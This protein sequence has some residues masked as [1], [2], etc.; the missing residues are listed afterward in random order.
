MS[1][2]RPDGRA[3]S[4]LPRPASLEPLWGRLDASRGLRLATAPGASPAL[5]R[6]LA[7]QQRRIDALT[8]PSHEDA[9][10]LRIAV[11]HDDG[12]RP[13]LDDDERFSLRIT[14]AGAELWAA[15]R[16]GVAHGLERVLQLVD[17]AGPG[18]GL[19]A[20]WIDDAPRF[21][22]RGLMLDLARRPY[23]LATLLRTLDGMAA[24]GLNVLHLHLNDDQGFAIEV[25]GT[26]E[27]HTHGGVRGH[28]GV[29]EVRRLVDEAADRSI[30]V[31]PEL[32]VPG[33]AGAIL[34]ARPELAAGTPP[35]GLPRRFGPGRHALDPSR[36]ATWTLL[37]A[38]V[39]DLADLFP[40]PVL[41]LGGDEVHPEVY[42]F[43][44][45][46]R[47][48]WMAE[49]DLE[50]ARAVQDWFLARMV[51]LLARHDR[52]PVG[53][54]ETLGPRTP[55]TLTIQAWRGAGALEAA[56]AAGHDA[57]FSS[58]WYLDLFYPAA[59]HYA[60]DPGAGA[61]DL[62][63]AER[64]LLG[65]PEL[66][67]VRRGL[68]G[69][70]ASAS[71]PGGRAGAPRGRLLGGEGCL[72]SELAAPH[73]LD[74][75]L[76]GRLAAVAERLWSSPASDAE[77]EL[78]DFYA[79]LPRLLAHLEAATDCRPLT[80]TAAN[81][82]RIGVEPGELHAVDVVL[83][84]LEPLR[85]YRRLLGPER[86]A[87]RSHATSGLGDAATVRPYDA[88]TPLD[89]PVDLIPPESLDARAFAAEL[90]A[91]DAEPTDE[92][93]EV[94]LRDRAHAWRMARYALWGV[95]DRLPAFARL[96]GHVDALA[97][98]AEVLDDWLEA[99]AA[100]TPPPA[101][102]VE[103]V[104]DLEA[105]LDPAAELRLAVLP[106]LLERLGDAP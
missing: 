104:T 5:A 85:W 106:P 16:A 65:Q 69:L 83:R 4:L 37:D 95:R 2:A 80:A 20:V 62:A 39:G 23:D 101:G 58:G 57:L 42:A 63:A 27:L 13:A 87:G 6:L 99:R 30:R 77:A 86:A 76:Y 93:R 11:E 46:P 91:F 18:P 59:W 84:A 103:R 43:E 10:R 74:V 71:S 92:V 90:A 17:R 102:L 29:D 66:A 67:G 100:G 50:D 96:G 60:F 79:R 14:S 28:L 52:R 72:W 73:V 61:D 88:D 54:D 56:L 82:L 94:V 105:G 35:D 34:W 51:E 64:A 89:A 26:P 47:R 38:L 19:P 49:H 3:P 41:H 7:R 81:L 9:P 32:D 22:W 70:M 21:P 55:E 12:A 1:E 48:A 8:S 31:V 25:P 40:D 15:T 97:E 68:A 44:D 33:H 75:R 45:E 53:W 36:D 98:L 24:L 78:D